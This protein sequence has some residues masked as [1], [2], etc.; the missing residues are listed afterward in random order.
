[1]DHLFFSFSHIVPM[2][3]LLLESLLSLLKIK[4][5]EKLVASKHVPLN[6]VV[7]RFNQVMVDLHLFELSSVGVMHEVESI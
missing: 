2:F 4:S 6:L 3:L 5:L 1:M 7:I